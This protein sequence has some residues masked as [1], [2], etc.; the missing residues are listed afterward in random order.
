MLEKCVKSEWGF[1]LGCWHAIGSPRLPWSSVCGSGVWN[2]LHWQRGPS[3]A[4]PVQ[5][6]GSRWF[7]LPL[8]PSEPVHGALP[9]ASPESSGLPCRCLMFRR[10]NPGVL[11]VVVRANLLT[12][13]PP[14]VTDRFL[15]QPGAPAGAGAAQPGGSVRNP[16][17]TAVVCLTSYKFIQSTSPKTL[18]RGLL[19]WNL[20]GGL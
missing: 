3:W 4:E 11:V 16:S 10:A 6:T 8:N 2:H 13:P 20:S 1:G 7:Q 9:S 15:L 19:E 14:A 5:P 12:S 18:G 17:G